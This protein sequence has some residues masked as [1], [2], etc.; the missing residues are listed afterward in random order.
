MLV[1]LVGGDCIRLIDYMFQARERLFLGGAAATRAE[2]PEAALVQTVIE[3]VKQFW[4]RLDQKAES[5]VTW[6][7]ASSKS[8]AA[9]EGFET[10]LC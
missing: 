10:G 5:F 1:Q 6:A 3:A 8:G 2:D 9:P 7:S 4:N